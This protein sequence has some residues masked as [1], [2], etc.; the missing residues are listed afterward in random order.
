[1]DQTFK[2]ISFYFVE[3]R[4][5]VVLWSGVELFEPDGVGSDFSSSACCA[6]LG[7][8]LTFSGPQ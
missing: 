5:I 4:G 8:L 6:A 3:Q 1:M 7:T 2:G